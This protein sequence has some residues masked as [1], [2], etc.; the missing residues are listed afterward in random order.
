[1]TNLI[2]LPW[3]NSANLLGECEDSATGWNNEKL[4]MLLIAQ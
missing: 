3:W 2:F 1:M 4:F